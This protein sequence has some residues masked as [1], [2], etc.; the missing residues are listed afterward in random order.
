MK[1]TEEILKEARYWIHT[2]AT[3]ESK[4]KEKGETIN[5]TP[6]DLKLKDLAEINICFNT[7]YDT[8]FVKCFYLNSKKS[9]RFFINLEDVE[10]WFDI[11]R[12][13]YSMKKIKPKPNFGSTEKGDK[14]DEED[15]DD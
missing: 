14:D 8:V 13:F 12:F 11:A 9:F 3:N 15:W 5:Q 2:N 7:K 1:I 6:K 4:A 10:E